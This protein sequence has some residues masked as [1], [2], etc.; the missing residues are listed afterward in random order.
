[1]SVPRRNTKKPSGKYVT[2][3]LEGALYRRFFREAVARK[4]TVGKILKERILRNDEGNLSIYDRVKHLIGE[5]DGP[6]D[7][8]TNP[9]YLKGFGEDLGKFKK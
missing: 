1:M 8:S 3:Y 7:L 6:Q 5:V 9:K 2:I 4:L